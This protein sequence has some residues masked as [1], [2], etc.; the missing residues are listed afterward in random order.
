[1]RSTALV[2]I[3]GKGPQDAQRASPRIRCRDMRSFVA[4]L[5]LAG[6]VSTLTAASA[7]PS[8][9]CSRESFPVG[10]Q[11]VAVTVCAGAPEG[12]T[13]AVTET[14]RGAST[15]FT[16]NA[17]ID[18]LPGAGVSRT[19][20]DVSLTPLNLPYTLHLTLAYHGGEV[21]IEHAL[22]LPGAV[23]LK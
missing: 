4:T 16:H 15:S 2:R 18:V 20:D 9:K 22:L 7:Q 5:A 17:S 11:A 13:L 10:G 12:R 21:T 3:P 19:V 14:I 8:Q 23:P 6:T 1:M